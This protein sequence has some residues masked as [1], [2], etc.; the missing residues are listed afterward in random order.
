MLLTHSGL[1]FGG[2]LIN[3][4]M[5]VHVGELLITWHCEFGPH[6]DGWQGFIGFVGSSAGIL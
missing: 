5:H 3:P 6:G 4:F 2:E 1:Q